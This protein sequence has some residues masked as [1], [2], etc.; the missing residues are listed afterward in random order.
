M[1]QVDSTRFRRLPPS[2]PPILPPPPRATSELCPVGI[3]GTNGKT[4]TSAWIAAALAAARTTPILRTSTV[5]Y[6]LDDEALGLPS[7]YKAFVG[8]MSF[9]AARGA[10]DVV[11]ELT[12]NALMH[13]Y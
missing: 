9:A 3:T 2:R 13:G 7:D 8:M 12:S 10:R 1:L 4:T 11:L 5:G 6:Y